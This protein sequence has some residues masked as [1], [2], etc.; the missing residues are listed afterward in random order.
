MSSRTRCKIIS[1]TF[2][3]RARKKTYAVSVC[4]INRGAVLLLLYASF[5][6]APRAPWP[7]PVHFGLNMITDGIDWRTGGEP[8]KYSTSPSYFRSAPARTRRSLKQCYRRWGDSP[9]YS[10]SDRRAGLSLQIAVKVRVKF[11]VVCCNNYIS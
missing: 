2:F 9:C 10:T 4:R 7:L 8:V 1:R 6:L 5:L 11:S 3:T